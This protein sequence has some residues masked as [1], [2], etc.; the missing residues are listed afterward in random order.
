MT[1]FIGIIITIWALM[2]TI[3]LGFVCYNIATKGHKPIAV[4]PVVLALV[5]GFGYSIVTTFYYANQASESVASQ[6]KTNPN[7][8]PNKPTS[9][10]NLYR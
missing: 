9:P 6:L 8:N 7:A 2:G 4:L 5:V 10:S 3:V 1:L